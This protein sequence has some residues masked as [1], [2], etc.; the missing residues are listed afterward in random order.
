MNPD[1]LLF[2]LLPVAA[3]SGWWL[4]RRSLPST[5][6]SSRLD[7]SSDYFVGLNYLLNEQPDKAVDV[8]IKM[9]EV[10]SETVET[11]LALGNLFRRRGE[12]DRAIRI[13]QNLIA[14]PTLTRDQRAQALLELAKD[15]MRAGVLDRAESLFLELAENKDHR[16]A[17]LDHLLDIYQQEKDWEKAITVSHS[18]ENLG[19]RH[20]SNM[21]AQ[22]CCEL[23]ERAYHRGEFKLAMRTVKRALGYDKQCV[24]ASLL[25]AKMECDNAN[26]RAAIKAYRQVETQDPAYL[27]EIIEPLL[28]CYHSLGQIDEAEAYL[29]GL[30]QQYGGVTVMLALAELTR[31]KAGDQAAA[32]TLAQAM[33]K[34]PSIRGLEKLLSLLVASREGEIREMLLQIHRYVDRLVETQ[35]AYHCKN[36]GFN[37]KTLHWQCPTCRKWGTVKPM[38]ADQEPV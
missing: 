10:D 16:G 24:R 3:A 22:F 14:R 21:S 15:Y 12:G 36:C 17:A 20:T 35:A 23:A 2:L 28:R 13:H 1:L 18:I 11:H 19:R 31:I 33:E 9:L 38:Q 26:Q 25:L 8:F 32:N 30:S 4:A 34:Q 6:N 7:H 5:Q 29:K 37:A 27:T